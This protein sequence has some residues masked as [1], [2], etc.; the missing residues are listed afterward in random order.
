[1]ELSKCKL[2][3]GEAAEDWTCRR[4]HVTCSTKGCEVRDMSLGPSQWQKLMAEKEEE[5]EPMIVVDDERL[6]NGATNPYQILAVQYP[7]RVYGAFLTL[8]EAVERLA[9]QRRREEE[10]AARRAVHPTTN[11]GESDGSLD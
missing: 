4:G 1:M 7:V 9:A 11:T 3:G 10:S 8:D 6:L 2:C 5:V